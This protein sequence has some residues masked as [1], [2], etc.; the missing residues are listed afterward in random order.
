M[1]N[2][3]MENYSQIHYQSWVYR[4]KMLNTYKVFAEYLFVE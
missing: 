2:T 4:I 1:I 3:K